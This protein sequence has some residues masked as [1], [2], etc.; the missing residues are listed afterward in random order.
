MAAAAATV[1]RLIAGGPPP[2]VIVIGL[3]D[4][5]LLDALEAAGVPTR[6]LAIEP[7]PTRTAAMLA[8]RD[9]SAWTDTGRLTLLRGP[10][11]EGAAEAWRLFGRRPPKPPVIM[12]P[13]VARESARGAAE[14]RQVVRRILDGIDAN[15]AARRQF[16]GRYLLN[17]LRNLPVIAREG[18]AGTLTGMFAGVPAVVV[19]AGPSLDQNFDVIRDLATHALVIAVDTALRPLLTAGITPH[20][21]VAVDPSELNGRHLRDLPPGGQPWLVA[22]GSLDP[23]VFSGFTDRTFTFRVS[24]HDPWPWLDELGAG[25]GSLRAWGSVLTTAFDLA[26]QAG[27][28]PIVFAGADLAYSRGLQYCRHTT[29]EPLWAECPT[30]ESRAARFA[31]HLATQPTSCVP[32][33]AGGDVLTAPHFVQFRDWIVARAAEAGPCRVANVTGHGILAGH[34]ILQV[35]EEA[36]REM[37][38]PPA[39]RIPSIAQSLARA[40]RAGLDTR[41]AAAARIAGALADP[42]CRPLARWL[43]FAGDA[44]SAEQIAVEVAVGAHGLRA[45]SE[46]HAFLAEER[47]RYEAGAAT[48]EAARVLI[49]PDYDFFQAQA[50]SQV[51][52]AFR[53]LTPPSP[54]GA[55]PASPA[56]LD[57]LDVLDVGCGLGRVM[58]AVVR[59]GHRADGVDISPRLIA[60]ARRAPALA[61]SRFF[62]S[63]GDDCG[64]APEVEYDMVTMFHVFHRVRPRRVR[65]SLLASAARTL[66]PGGTVFIQMPFFPDRRRDTVPRP[67]VTWDSDSLV[68]DGPMPGEVWITADQLPD[69]FGDLSANFTDIRFQFV[70]FPA[71]TPRFGLAPGERLAHL[72]ITATTTPVLASKVFRP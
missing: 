14:A 15:E 34:P 21:V 44:V 43:D 59:A 37:V 47:D 5:W 16:A 10:A 23:A 41:A 30:D 6:V 4:G 33:V 57:V 71:A 39:S 65:R 53:D 58:E 1:S 27:C 62:V 3:G 35:T 63:R 54:S 55:G 60:H 67:H 40:W 61:A 17:S 7:N 31:T 64:D 68:S 8:R 51:A 69:V 49:H 20:L 18:D 48:V 28:E 32:A 29:Y 52:Y 25:R 22:E 50:A 45:A 38:L 46:L 56:A 9:W 72:L 12:S 66:R 36:A 42:S 26:C 19:G 13:A 70:D 24:Q 11:Y 2:I